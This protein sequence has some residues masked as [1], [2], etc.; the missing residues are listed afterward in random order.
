MSDVIRVALPGYDAL[1]DTNTDHFSLYADI[2][3][4]LIKRMLSDTATINDPSGGSPT[5]LT[6]PH[7]LGYIPFFMVH[8]YDEV[9][10][11]WRIL[12]NQN[13][14]FSVPDALCGADDTNLYI[15][16]FGS[17]SSG[18]IEV[19]YDIFFD[20]MSDTTAPTI[21][22]SPKVFK[23][24]RPGIQ[25]STSKNP[26]DYIMHA[27]LNNMKIL[28]SGVTTIDCNGLTTVTIPHGAD[29]Q[30]PFKY[31]MFIH[32]PF[33]D[34]TVILGGS[35]VTNVLNDSE[36]TQWFGSYM[37]DTNI[38]VEKNHANI[39]ELFEFSYIIYGSGKD[40]TVD[41]TAPVIAL[42][43]S[44]KDAKTETNPDNF[45]FHSKFPTLKYYYSSVYSYTATASHLITLPHNLGYVPFFIGFV[46]DISGL[47]AGGYA[48][49][50]Y[51]FGRSSLLTPLKDVGAF[52]FADDINIYLKIF[53]QPNANGTA[54]IF[55]FYYKVF[56]NNL[57]I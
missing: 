12:N 53:Y 36:S 16:N 49:M 41:N 46:E 39:T 50:P 6:I 51:Y 47:I 5:I 18:H 54:F 32:S 43:A 15:Y 22:E 7:N 4:V 17:H 3:N 27:D 31:L 48:I 14:A 40:N 9:V 10:S 11:G 25:G 1:E 21:T 34:A 42:A 55:N 8:M 57:N 44:G 26:N 2:D 28:K 19:A 45:N 30:A 52:M 38:Y 56:L 13:N 37:D 33:D 20:N 24:A 29:V 35:T 23:V